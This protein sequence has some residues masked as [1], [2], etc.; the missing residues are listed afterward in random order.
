MLARSEKQENN[1]D[2]SSCSLVSWCVVMWWWWWWR[3]EK[4][5]SP[6]ELKISPS[7]YK[8]PIRVRAEL[9]REYQLYHHQTQGWY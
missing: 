1:Y 9:G 8:H 3:M 6:L 4:P 2:C 7:D 5:I